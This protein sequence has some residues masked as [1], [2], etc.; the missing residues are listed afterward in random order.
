MYNSWQMAEHRVSELAELAY[1]SFPVSRGGPE[2]QIYLMRA[3]SH[4]VTNMVVPPFGQFERELVVMLDNFF[5]NP[6][7]R[8]PPLNPG[9][10]SLEKRQRP[11]LLYEAFKGVSNQNLGEIAEVCI[12]YQVDGDHRFMVERDRRGTSV[13][14][15]LII[16]PDAKTDQELGLRIGHPVFRDLFV[17]LRQTWRDPQAQDRIRSLGISRR[18]DEID[19]YHLCT[20]VGRSL[21]HVAKVWQSRNGNQP[22]FP[23]AG[24]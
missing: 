11:K 1:Q 3:A 13:V 5:K 12:A 17:R 16:N 24:I 22:F 8:H 10:F 19:C 23:P 4:L 7:L 9:E 18:N 2:A 21:D 14:R 20:T 15:D 6:D